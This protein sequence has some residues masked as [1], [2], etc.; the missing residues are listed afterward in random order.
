M[1]E[2][3]KYKKI[4]SLKQYNQYCDALEE[5]IY[6]EDKSFKDEIELLE[7]LIADYD[8]S[9]Q[10][11]TSK[12]L[13]PV[14]LLKSILTDAGMNQKELA[15]QLGVSKQLISDVLGY[16]R[17]I[18]KPLVKKLAQFFKMN[19]EAF[20]REYSLKKDKISVA[21]EDVVVY[22]SKK[23]SIRKPAKKV[24][25]KKVVMAKKTTVKK[26]TKAKKAVAKK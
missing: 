10:Q 20:S 23:K 9:L 2:I 12:K 17:N 4:K 3:L 11:E 25:A 24:V 19:E 18:S 15:V 21:A 14:E 16:R 6:K 5:L 22:K 13:N 7:I 1:K 8:R 26:K